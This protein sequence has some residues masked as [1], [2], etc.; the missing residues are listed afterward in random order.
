MLKQTTMMTL[1]PTLSNSLKMRIINRFGANY[2]LQTSTFGT[3]YFECATPVELFR[4]V[5]YG[6]EEKTL[7]SFLFLLKDDDVVWDV[8]ASVGLFTVYSAPIVQKVLSFEPEPNIY[9]RLT[10][11]VK[12]NALMNVETHQMGLG[13]K[14]NTMR[15]Q[16]SGVNGFSPSLMNLGRHTSTIEV[17]IDTID[18]LVAAGLPTPT[19]LKIDIEGAEQMALSG[20]ANLLAGPHRPRLIFMEIHPNFLPNASADEQAIQA[21]LEQNAYKIL[22]TQKRDDQ[23][24]LIA[25]Q[26]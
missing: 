23:Y 2:T 8:G 9:A 18:N 19:V 15:L 20:A 6:G 7:G 11:N 26:V 22:N 25:V 3:R 24:H 1:L 4:T 5:H 21:L 13:D 10:N 14:K 16:T 17:P 12:T